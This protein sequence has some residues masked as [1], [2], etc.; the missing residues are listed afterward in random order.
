MPPRTEQLQIRV[1]RQEKARLRRLA[2]AAGLDLSGYVLSRALPPADTRFAELTRA[3]A[4]PASRRFALAAV[5][6][7]LVAC[8]PASFSPAVAAPE[9]GALSAY[10]QNY[11][12]ALVEEAA[13]RN[14]VA[15]PDWVA[16]VEPLDAP[17][18]AAPLTS[19]RLHLL[20]T[21][22]VPFKRRNI[23]VDSALGARV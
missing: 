16:D 7:F 6:D 11:V 22:P 13:G 15:P 18:F 10:D 20:R 12:A 1:T 23:F 14:G 4:D 3:V 5:N 21:S 8:T 19:L 9:L 2:S 17:R